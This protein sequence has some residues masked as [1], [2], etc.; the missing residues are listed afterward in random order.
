MG[1]GG[2]GILPIIEVALENE[3]IAFLEVGKE[4]GGL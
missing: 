4:I 1:C 3:E 2:R